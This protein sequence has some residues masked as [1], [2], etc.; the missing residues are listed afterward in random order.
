MTDPIFSI[1]DSHAHIWVN[2]HAFAWSP[3]VSPTPSYDATPHDLL[4]HMEQEAISATVLVQY[5]GYKWDNEYVARAL[6]LAPDRFAGVCRVNPE[7]P[8][9]PED[10]TY[11]TTQRGFH[12][13]RISPQ[14]SSGGDWFDGPLMDPFFGCVGQLGIPLVLL[15]KAERLPRLLRLLDRHPDVDVVLD[16][17]ADCEPGNPQHLRSLQQLAENP[18]VLLKTGHMWA[19]SRQ[20]Y[21]W[22]DQLALLGAMR[23][24]F[25]ASR[26]MWG[27][28]W[29]MC[30]EHTTYQRA[31]SFIRDAATFLTHEDLAW[32]LGGTARRLWNLSPPKMSASS[33]PHPAS[34]PAPSHSRNA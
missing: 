20:D 15:S 3:D 12:G 17:F 19:N 23:D 5:I 24:L 1:V 7:D 32:L 31:L 30:R 25:G 33:D 16:H 18:R 6:A 29:P 4:Q 26:I 28:D 13:V 34:P 14:P 10:L 21:P 22:P 11:W 2:D 9:A 27:S 8:K